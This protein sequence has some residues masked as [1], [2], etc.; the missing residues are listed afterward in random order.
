MAAAV[1][2]VLASLALVLALMWWAWRHF[3]FTEDAERRV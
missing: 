1:Y 3:S 2:H